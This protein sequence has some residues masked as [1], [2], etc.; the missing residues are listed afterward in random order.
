MNTSRAPV[1]AVDI[2][3]GLP[4]DGSPLEGP[5]VRAAR[6]VTMGL[7]KRGMMIHPG[8]EFTGAVT[9]ADLGFPH[10]LIED[11]SIKLNIHSLAE[12]KLMLPARPPDGHKGTFGTVLIL[13]G[14]R[15][16][17]GAAALAARAASRSGVGLVYSAMPKDLAPV[18]E[19]LLVEAVKHVI[20]S[21]AGDRFDSRSI[22]AALGLASEADAVALGPGLSTLRGVSDFVNAFAGKH[23]GPLVIDADG[24][25]ALGENPELLKK[26][27][28]PTIITPHPGEMSR[29]SGISIQQIQSNR[30]AAAQDF[31]QR[32]GVTV[33]LKGAQTIIA[34]PDGET[35]INTSGNSGLAKGGSGDVLTGLI[36]GLLAQGLSAGRAARLGVFLHGLAGD[37]AAQKTGVRAMIP[38][39]VIDCLGKA[40]R[41]I[42][43]S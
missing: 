3:S 4:A 12:M 17:T 1:L 36:A 26:R 33:A 37:K 40:F 2:P 31:A 38:S 23:D 16:M 7:P 15:G 41:A 11:P 39:D 19:P 29:L 22:K 35:C 27:S 14:S 32:H 8:I 20:P 30:I 18:F 24:L 25:N 43:E 9:V 6:T 42:E 28:A 10:D 21:S 5:V 13:A 34:D